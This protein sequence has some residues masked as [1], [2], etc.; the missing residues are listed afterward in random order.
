[1]PPLLLFNAIN[2]ILVQSAISCPCQ[3]RFKEDLKEQ[4]YL[5]KEKKIEENKDS[6]GAYWIYKLL[7]LKR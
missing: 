2:Y 1:M 7:F 5:S 3:Q 4:A 6:A